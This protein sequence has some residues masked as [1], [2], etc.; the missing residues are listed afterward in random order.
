M[1]RGE[2][3]LRSQL[4]ALFAKAKMPT[5]PTLAAR[6][7]ELIDDPNAGASDFAAAIRVDGALSARLLKTANSAHYAQRIPVTTVERAVTVLGIRS[8]KSASLGFQLVGH[9]DKLGGAPFD[10]R[11]FWQHSLLRACVMRAIAKR[12]IPDREEE[13][14]LIGLLQDC[15]IPLLVQVLGCGYATLYRSRHLSPTAFHRVE[16]ESFPHTHV[17]AVRVMAA[18]WRLPEVIASPLCNHHRRPKPAQDPDETDRL[19]TI[20]YFV[21][22]LGFASDMT[23][24]PEEK[25]LAGFRASVL[26]LDDEA[27]QRV[28]SRASD[29]YQR[30]G[31]LFGDQLPESLDVTDLLSEANRQL[32]KVAGDADTRLL[33]IEAERESVRRE[34]QRLEGALR[35]YRERAAL[36]PLTNI[37]NRGAITEVTRRAIEENLDSG[38]AI[39]MIFADLD[40]FKKL[41][42]THGH[43][44]GDRVL[45]ATAGLLTREVG[46]VGSVGRYGGEEFVAVLRGVTPD[47]TRAIAERFV[48]R[49][50]GLDTAPL[51]FEGTVTCSLGAVWADSLPLSSAEELFGAADEQ[52]YRA[53]RAGKDRCFFA[54]LASAARDRGPHERS[55]NAVGGVAE[56]PRRRRARDDASL[57]ASLADVAT[58][59]NAAEAD[60]F[61]GMRKQERKRVVLPCRL[62]Y[63]TE[64][65]NEV[66]A[67][68]AVT[69]NIST[70]GIAL[71][72]PR[73]MVRAEAVEVV[74]RKEDSQL[75]LAGLVTFCRHIE[76]GIHEVG[77]QFVMHSVAPIISGSGTE[78]A[79]KIDWIANAV[80]AK[81]SGKLASA[82]NAVASD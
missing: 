12:L 73:P 74:M 66:R 71:L 81:R 53:K 62:H 41:N 23:V 7:L 3:G 1:A 35:E 70:G 79:L 4:T 2:N 68:K 50:R 9:L 21:G 17:E 30:A 39:G 28:L 32:C 37:L 72:V 58:K 46:Q 13:A 14:F 19:T 27:W 34:Q 52:M 59:L 75:F 36:D 15:G 54:V 65:G 11:T 63:F 18:E 69:R 67:E 77:V 16:K 78:S 51:G 38:A 24:D 47:A 56:T 6:I 76:G 42:D 80:D 10:M 29:E 64:S 26:G 55:G 31:I 49:L 44:V 60:G 43:G 5:S 22:A 61:V 40:D 82:E 45:K 33:D 48:Q 20:S 25:E 57:P 8:V